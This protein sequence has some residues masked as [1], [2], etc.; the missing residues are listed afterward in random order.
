VLAANAGIGALVVDGS[1]PKSSVAR[2]LDAL[3]PALEGCYQAAARAANADAHVSASVHLEI[4]VDGRTRNVAV[5]PMSLPGLQSCATATIARVRTKDRPD[6][7][8]VG[9]NFHL[10]F[11]P[12]AP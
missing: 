5:G 3:K 8:T 9:A 1:L 12:R 6:T 2:A 4:D 11:T 7:G 10:S